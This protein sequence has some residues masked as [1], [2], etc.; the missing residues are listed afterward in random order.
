ML[1]LANIAQG[2]L[3]TKPNID[4]TNPNY[5][6]ANAIY[7]DFVQDCVVSFA[8]VTNAIGT[9]PQIG[10][11]AQRTLVP[12][13]DQDIGVPGAYAWDAVITLASVIGQ[14]AGDANRYTAQRLA[15]VQAQSDQQVAQETAVKLA[16]ANYLAQAA[17][18]NCTP[19]VDVVGLSPS[20]SSNSLVPSADDIKRILASIYIPS[21]Q[22]AA[23]VARYLSVADV[24]LTITGRTTFLTSMHVCV[25]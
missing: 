5:V 17:A 20:S 23:D 22:K 15:T 12:D 19:S 16:M 9:V 11:L 24:D 8:N 3:Y 13:W 2:T 6:R 1:Q 10:T 21:Y 25:D 7:V 14:L 4:K 18:C